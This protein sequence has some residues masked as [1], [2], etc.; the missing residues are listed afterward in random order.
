M[1]IPSSV[2]GVLNRKGC[3][4]ALGNGAIRNP[5]SALGS[6][7]VRHGYSALGSIANLPLFV[8][9]APIVPSALGSKVDRKRTTKFGSLPCRGARARV[10]TRFPRRPRLL[11]L[12]GRVL[13]RALSFNR[14]NV[15]R[16][17]G[18]DPF[19]IIIVPKVALIAIIASTVFPMYAMLLPRLWS[20]RPTLG[21]G[22]SLA[23][24]PHFLQSRLLLRIGSLN[25]LVRTLVPPL[26]RSILEVAT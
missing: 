23:F 1:R 16:F 17:V 25:V 10:A 7:E 6:K 12:L 13:T 21:F 19:P 22:S 18:V 24:L 4:L 20:L 8:V 26:A 3:A 11:A 15:L 5:Q 9:N 2:D 14:F